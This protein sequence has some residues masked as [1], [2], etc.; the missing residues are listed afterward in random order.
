M[1][2]IRIRDN[3]FDMVRFLRSVKDDVPIIIT[4]YLEGKEAVLQQHCTEE[5]TERLIGM[6]KHY[7]AQGSRQ[8]PTLLFVSDVE[9][10]DAT[11]VENEPIIVVTFSCQQINCLRDKFGNVVDGREDEIH[12]VYYAWALQ[13]DEH[14]AFDADGHLLPPRWQLR[15][16]MIRGFHNL[17]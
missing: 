6:Y 17:L 9:L 11:F 8:D 13:Q 16:M 4:A 10:F 12:Q 5:M 1:R 3:T 7:E 2:R 14:G 15:E